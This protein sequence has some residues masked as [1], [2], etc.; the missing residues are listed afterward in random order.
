MARAV[1]ANARGVREEQWKRRWDRGGV[2]RLCPQWGETPKV[3][4][5]AKMNLS[6][7]EKLF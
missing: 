2:T 3:V 7:E 1:S 5:E 4:A 6:W